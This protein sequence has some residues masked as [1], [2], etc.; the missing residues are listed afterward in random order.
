MAGQTLAEGHTDASGRF[1]FARPAVLTG[2]ITVTL[3]TGEGHMAQAELNAERL[4]AERLGAAP[5]PPLS[6]SPPVAAAPGAT[7]ILPLTAA[8]Q[9]ALVTEAV[10]DAVARQVAPLLERIEQMDARMKFTDLLSG[11]FLI[12]G[13][14]GMALWARGR[15]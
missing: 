12:L 13:L 8:Q 4:G 1:A 7:A 15:K 10:S 6:P 5:P 3:D 9:E 2:G 11:L 14:A